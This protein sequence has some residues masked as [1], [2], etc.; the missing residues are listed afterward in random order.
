MS[1]LSLRLSY[2][3]QIFA[4]RVMNNPRPMLYSTHFLDCRTRPAFCDPVTVA[5][6]F[7]CEGDTPGKAYRSGV[8]YRLLAVA[9]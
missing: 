9:V 8:T 7:L 4:C 6:M 3:R 2:K 1:L 5:C